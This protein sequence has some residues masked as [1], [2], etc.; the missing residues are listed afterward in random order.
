MIVVKL[1][2]PTAQINIELS[3]LQVARIRSSGENATSST[4][5]AWH[6]YKYINVTS[7][8][9]RHLLIECPLRVATF[10]QFSALGSVLAP[11][12]TIAYVHTIFL[13]RLNIFKHAA[14]GLTFLPC[15]NSYIITK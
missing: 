1:F 15:C 5:T 12:G 13:S 11:N 9:I 10:S 14:C 8:T 4:S 6:A 3:I 7:I 2:A